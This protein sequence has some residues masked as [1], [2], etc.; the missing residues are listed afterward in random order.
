MTPKDL[1]SPRPAAA[2]SADVEFAL[3]LSRIIDSLKTDP[4]GLRQSVYELARYKLQEQLKDSP[5]EQAADALRSL[6]TAIQGVEAFTI[7]NDTVPEKA[8]PPPVSLRASALERPPRARVDVAQLETS[9]PALGTRS[10]SHSQRLVTRLIVALAAAAFVF[11]GFVF[12]RQDLRLSLFST[13][14]LDSAANPSSPSPAQP[15]AAPQPVAPPPPEPKPLLPSQYGVYAVDGGNLVDLRLLPGRPP[16]IRVAISA[17]LRIPPAAVLSN[18]HPTF[19]VYRRDAISHIVDRPEVRVVAK[20][21]REFAVSPAGAATR[22]ADTDAWIMRNFSIPFRSSPVKDSPEMYE[23]R[24][25]AVGAE[26]T[27]GRYALILEDQAYDFS[28]AGAV[29]DTRQCLE[30]IAASNGSFFSECKTP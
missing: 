13:R 26:L 27:P 30:R 3:V 23:I 9:E 12:Y 25:E 22:P 20:V 24:P 4:E 19:V 28:I 1:T 8:L 7:N 10:R 17:E 5:P 29:T 16:D 14:R 18:G 6:E 11:T 2:A 21:A 15:V